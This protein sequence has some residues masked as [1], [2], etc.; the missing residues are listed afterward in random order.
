MF[1]THAFWMTVV[2]WAI[3]TLLLPG[4]AGSMVSFNHAT[5]NTHSSPTSTNPTVAFDPLTAAII[6]L[7]AQVGYPYTSLERQLPDLDVVGFRWRV[8]NAAVSLAFAFA[9]AIAGGPRAFASGSRKEPQIQRLLTKDLPTERL[10]TEDALTS[11][12]PPVNREETE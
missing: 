11:S 6:R 10:P 7:A 9:E 12:G 5:P 3:P 4:I 8:L 2:H 1:Q